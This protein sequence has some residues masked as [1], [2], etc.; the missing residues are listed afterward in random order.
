[1]NDELDNLTS[2]IEQGFMQPGGWEQCRYLLGKFFKKLQDENERLEK[3]LI[4]VNTSLQVV[5]NNL[6]EY[7]EIKI[8]LI[9]E[10][11]GE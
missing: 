4:K 5:R 9:K 3:D 7:Y 1:M 10:T 11:A 2:G 8:K 6:K